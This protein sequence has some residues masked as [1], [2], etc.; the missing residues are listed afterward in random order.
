MSVVREGYPVDTP[1]LIHPGHTLTIYPPLSVVNLL[2]YDMQLQLSGRETGRMVRRGEKLSHYD[3]SRWGLLL[4]PRPHPLLCGTHVYR[5]GCQQ[6]FIWK[7]LKVGARLRFKENG[8]Q[9]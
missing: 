4:W 5:V 6:C 3:V 2:P 8:G 1:P 7:C 9:T